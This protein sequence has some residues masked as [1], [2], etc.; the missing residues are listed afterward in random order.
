MF[1]GDFAWGVATASY[2]IEGAVNEDGRAASIW[3]TFSHT[4]GTIENGDTG[5]DACDHYHRYLEDVELIARLGVGWYRFSVAWPRL[6]PNGRGAL[7][8]AGLDFYSRLIDAL[9]ERSVEPW[10]TLYHWD[11]P[12]V[13]EDAGGWPARDTASNARH[14]DHFHHR[15]KHLLEGLHLRD[16]ADFHDQR[17]DGPR[18]DRPFPGRLAVHPADRRHRRRGGGSHRTGD[19]SRLLVQRRTVSGLTAGSVNG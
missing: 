16:L 5:D 15:L 4:P 7:N 10:V 18:R 12:Q 2:Q 19:D 3:D 1:P 14:R 17:G 8:E 6:Q 9:L 11:L 13:L